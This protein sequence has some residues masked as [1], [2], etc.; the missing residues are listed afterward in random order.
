MLVLLFVMRK[1]HPT[2]Y[3]K[4]SHG[5]MTIEPQSGWASEWSS[6]FQR[7]QLTHKIQ[8]RIKSAFPRYDNGWPERTAGGGQGQRAAP[9]TKLHFGHCAITVALNTVRT[10]G[11]Q[12]G[13]ATGTGPLN[14][15]WSEGNRS[16]ESDES[17]FNY[18]RLNYHEYIDW[19]VDWV[20]PPN[21]KSVI[22]KIH[23]PT[24]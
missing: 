15:H 9:K 4:Y 23:P 10:N 18:M 16:A 19:S 20:G 1:C 8:L 14:V 21:M 7:M 12:D 3:R 11:G 5:E 22:C 2:K 24:N 13:W 6:S 17:P